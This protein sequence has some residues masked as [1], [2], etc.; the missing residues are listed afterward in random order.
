MSA[1][2]AKCARVI[3]S[4]V[5]AVALLVC[6]AGR[7][8]LAAPPPM[9]RVAVVIGSNAPPP[10]RSPLRYAHDDAT[11]LAE[12]LEHVGGFAP[13]DVKVLLDPRPREILDELERVAAT[14]RDA[15][16][17]VLFVFYYSGHSDG[18]SLFPHGEPIGLSDVRSRVERLGA[19]IR[20]GILDTCRGGS[21]T[22]SKGLTV[23]PPLEMADLLN[24]GTEGTALVSSSSG[25]ENAH[26]AADVRGS[27]FTHYFTAG[28]RGAADRAGDGNVTL[29]EAFD[30]AK[31][32]T[33]RD[34]ARLAKTPQ[35]PSF[36][37]ALRGRQDI[38]LTVLSPSTSAL[39][40][41]GAKAS[42]EVI[43]LPSGVTV[44]DAPAGGAP[45][46]VA[47][48][49]GRYLVRSVVDGQVHA[50]EIEVRAG[51]TTSLSE[52][53]LEATGSQALAMKG[54]DVEG[55]D[56]DDE[57]DD[58]TPAPPKK[59]EA[60]LTVD[61]RFPRCNG[62]DPEKT[63]RASSGCAGVFGVR[64]SIVDVVGPSSTQ[65]TGFE[66]SADSEE[67]WR[68]KLLSGVWQYKL[69][70]G[71]GGA[72]LEGTMFVDTA[73]GFRV[74]VTQYEGPV[75]RAGLEAYLIGDDALY[76]SLFELP[77]A[78]LGW[79]WARGHAVVE[80]A[81]TAGIAL[82]GRFRAWQEPTRDIGTGLAYGGRV[83]L[84][85]PW[86]RLSASAERLP[87]GDTL[88]YVDAGTATLCA[89]AAP[90]AICGDAMVEQGHVLESGGQP[91][92][93]A[94]YGGLTLGITGEH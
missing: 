76:S 40:V 55:D 38:V 52:G 30:Y 90:V 59:H 82:I 2:V 74:P 12:V 39:V 36:D 48:P 75:I 21:W 14:A 70:I 3:V 20:I 24:V 15:G 69:G 65:R 16:G 1:V 46:R 11:E 77:Q 79:Q 49:P 23:G 35:H 91:F 44:A 6:P 57:D 71:G 93:R 9:R 50:K 51:E 67:Y 19:R 17:N 84:Q 29:E 28:L 31:E 86:V 92:A 37:L 60:D 68:N 61:W 43:H 22:Q 80:V 5:L 63:V 8:A 45:L 26:E 56:S 47:V 25:L 83:S 4:A 32:R 58:D 34:S 7:P 73:F 62:T 33:V 78:Q 85:I 10:G 13:A 41:T 27:F 53:Q 81:A 94:A 66:V 87:S 89:V 72:G 88:D 18:Q 64:G 42:L 54:D